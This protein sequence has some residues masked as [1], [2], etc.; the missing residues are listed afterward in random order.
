MARAGDPS[1]IECSLHETNVHILVCTLVKEFDLSSSA[2]LGCG[3]YLG[4]S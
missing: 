4:E 3:E 1:Q 2:F